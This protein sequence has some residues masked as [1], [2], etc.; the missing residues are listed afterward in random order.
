MTVARDLES[1]TLLDRGVIVASCLG[2]AVAA[3]L[4]PASVQ[5][6]NWPASGPVRIA[7]FA[8]FSRLWLAIVLA[9]V[10]SAAICFAG[11][12]ARAESAARARAV[13][14]LSLLWLWTLPYW[15]WLPDRAPSLLALG[16]P[17]RWLVAGAAVGGVLWSW[18]RAF[19]GQL[20][21]WAQ[22]SRLSLF[23]LTLV[24]Y[25]V[26]GLRSLSTIGVSGDEPH[27]LVI[28][29][30][31]LTDHDLKIENNHL[32]RDYRAFFAGE[33]RPDYLRRGQNGEIYSI[34]SPGLPVL[35]LPGYA[36]AGA[37][38]AV[39]TM[40]LFGALAALAVFDVAL[41]VGGGSAPFLTWL[42]VCLTVPFVP[43]T[44]MLYPE[45]VGAAIAAWSV[46]W[47]AAPLP[48]RSR[49]WVWRGVWLATLPWLHTKFVVLLAILVIFLAARLRGRVK[50]MSALA[51]P[52]AGPV[53]LLH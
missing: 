35:L 46:W 49:A 19:A 12:G 22:L 48:S 51:V 33:L 40:C 15:P 29:R 17:A 50:D 53:R 39:L 25:V 7:I 32:N 42:S 27:Y 10:A 24:V 8:P 43:H 37:P 28:T 45:T 20:G 18:V 44:W 34:H 6:A 26:L 2:T 41:L 13:A 21:E 31:L 36:L 14:P 23:L 47:L 30:S 1:G 11:R 5:I 3:W 38:G 52:L 4:E 16:G 9:L